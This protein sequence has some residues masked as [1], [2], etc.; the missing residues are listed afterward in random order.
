MNKMKEMNDWL[1]P[2]PLTT[3]QLV[4]FREEQVKVVATLLANVPEK[5]TC[6]GC[7]L[8]GVCRL[9]WDAYNTDGDC[10]YDK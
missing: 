6:D 1:R 7:G 2:E 3:E 8:A 9:A 10:L 4:K 5:F